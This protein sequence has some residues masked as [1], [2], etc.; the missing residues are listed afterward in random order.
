[1]KMCNTPPRASTHKAVRIDFAADSLICGATSVAPVV[2]VTVAVASAEFVA[3]SKLE[4]ASAESLTNWS[5]SFPMATA[6][7]NPMAPE[8]TSDPAFAIWVTQRKDLAT[9]TS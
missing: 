2:A 7:P 5:V 1:M 9:G 4:S 8:A 3:D 6:T